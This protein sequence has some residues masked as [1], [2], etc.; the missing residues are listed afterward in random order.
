VDLPE[1]FKWSK[2]GTKAGGV[3]LAV[4][5]LIM[6]LNTKFDVSMEWIGEWWPLGAVVLGIYLVLKSRGEE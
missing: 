6:L 1:D 5:G 3:I 2:G 4:F